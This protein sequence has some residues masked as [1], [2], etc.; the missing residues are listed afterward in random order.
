MRMPPWI[1]IMPLGLDVAREQLA[2]HD[3]GNVLRSD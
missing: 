3:T 1:L 2:I